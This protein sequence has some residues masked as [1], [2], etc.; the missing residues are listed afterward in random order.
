MPNFSYTRTA[1]LAGYRKDFP[2]ASPADIWAMVLSNRQGAFN[3][4]SAKSKQS[5]P[6][7]L[8]WFG[9]EPNLY[10][11]RMKAFHCIDICF[12]FKNTD[13]MY[14]HTGG[15]ARPRALA[16]KMSASLLAFM[17]TGNPNVPSLPNWP[18]F[19]ATNAETLI[20]NDSCQVKNK[21]DGNGLAALMA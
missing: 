7:Y 8:A 16:D 3:T 9:W 19:S 6:V 10:D 13:R 5:A 14:T 15:G 18:K 1:I 4:S 12:W 11:G 20:L 17:R 21:P 2:E